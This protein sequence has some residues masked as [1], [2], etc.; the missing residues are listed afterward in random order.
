MRKKLVYVA[1]F[2]GTVKLTTNGKR[3]GG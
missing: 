3:I 2:F 1:T